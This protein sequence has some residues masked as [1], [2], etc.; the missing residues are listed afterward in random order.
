MRFSNFLFQPF[1]ENPSE[2]KIIS[3][4]LMLKSGLI[5]QETSG[6]YT[7]MPIGYRVLKKII[8][9]IEQEHENIGIN[10]I[11]MP[12]IQSSDIYGKLVIGMRLM[13]KKC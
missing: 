10:Q 6:I 3:H 2:A 11:L 7:W 8:K 5:K 9:I 1:R 12:T 13:E 4:T